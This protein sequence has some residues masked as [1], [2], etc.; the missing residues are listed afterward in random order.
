MLVGG[1]IQGENLVREF[2]EIR[3]AFE[4]MKKSFGG[5]KTSQNSEVD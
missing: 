2:G 4:V 1:P 5:S 3:A